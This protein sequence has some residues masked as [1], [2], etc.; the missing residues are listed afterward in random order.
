L[1]SNA[2]LDYLGRNDQ[3][4]KIRGY[5]IEPGEIE[6]VLRQHPSVREALV[7]AQEE[8]RGEKRLVAYV[9]LDKKRTVSIG[10]LR[11][12]VSTQVPDYMVP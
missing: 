9:V 10:E 2:G 5:R 4:V 12:F 3:Q 11:N 7:V 6:S 1:S 8:K